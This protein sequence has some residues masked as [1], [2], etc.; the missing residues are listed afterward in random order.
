MEVFWSL[1]VDLSNAI[2]QSLC[3]S[4]SMSFRSTL[5]TVPVQ[6]PQSLERTVTFLSL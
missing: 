3:A 1:D 4:V 2:D 6:R 5:F